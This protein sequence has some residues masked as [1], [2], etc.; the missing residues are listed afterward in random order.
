M[1]TRKNIQ[2][3]VEGN[4]LEDVCILARLVPRFPSHGW[5]DVLL[6][7]RLSTKC[8]DALGKRETDGWQPV[9]GSSFP[10][11]IQTSVKLMFFNGKYLIG[12]REY[13][14]Q[15]NINSFHRNI[16]QA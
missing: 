8:N 12:Y 15:D 5:S 1:R 16:Y 13:M 6:V 14:L 11:A 2:K 9:G 4:G 7:S 3:Y 10:P